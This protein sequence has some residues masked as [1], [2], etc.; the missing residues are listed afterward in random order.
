MKILIVDDDLFYSTV[1]SDILSPFGSC[2]T[3][4]NGPD[5]IA[6]FEKAISERNPYHLIALDIIMPGMDGC[7]ILKRVRQIEDSLGSADSNPVK[8]I[9]VTSDTDV[10]TIL[11]S[12]NAKCDAYVNKPVSAAA[13]MEKLRFLGLIS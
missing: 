11:T 4:S 10:D 13:I 9:M 8:I 1:L 2:D 5:A 6:L 12:Y 3:V 7:Q